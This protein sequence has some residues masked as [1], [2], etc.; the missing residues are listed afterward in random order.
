V[1]LTS[2]LDVKFPYANQAKRL[3]SHWLTSQTP[4]DLTSPKW[5]ICYLQVKEVFIFIR[6]KFEEVSIVLI[7]DP[8]ELSIKGEYD[9][10]D[11][12]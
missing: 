1:F 12:L 11:F 2:R 10:V 4:Q 8:T 3:S 6:I 7:V 9:E 5:N